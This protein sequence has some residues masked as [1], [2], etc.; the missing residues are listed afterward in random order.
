MLVLKSTIRFIIS[1]VIRMIPLWERL[2]FS[3]FLSSDIKKQNKCTCF[4]TST[5]A[6]VCTIFFEHSHSYRHCYFWMRFSKSN[7]C[8]DRICF[9][10][11]LCPLKTSMLFCTN[12]RFKCVLYRCNIVQLSEFFTS[13]AMFR[14]NNVDTENNI[15]YGIVVQLE[16]I[17]MSKNKPHFLY[18]IAGCT[19]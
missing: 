12:I 3:S 11:Y 13:N 17:E 4:T 6:N 9:L 2:L 18:V 19:W 1:I 10:A 15:L 8:P 16:M 7:T 5:F 14:L